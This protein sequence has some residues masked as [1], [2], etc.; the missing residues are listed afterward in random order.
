LPRRKKILVTP[1]DWGLGHAARCIP[2][3]RM[4]MKKNCDVVIA[5]CGRTFSLLRK[6]F[7]GMEMTWL[8]EYNPVYP[9]DDSMG[10]TMALQLPKFLKAIRQEHNEVRDIVKK[11]SID[12]VISDNRYGCYHEKVPSVFVTHQ[13]NILMPES[14]KW[15]EKL[16]NSY[17][18]RQIKK[19]TQCWVPAPAN[20]P[21]HSLTENPDGLPVKYIGYLSRMEKVPTQKKYGVCVICSGPEP[22]RTLME[23]MFNGDLKNLP[24]NTILVKGQTEKLNPYFNKE[25]QHLIANYLTTED[26]NEVLAESEIVFS[27]PGYST[28]MD[29]AKIG[30]KAVFIPTPGQTE[31]EYIAA[32]LM[33]QNIAL[34]VPQSGFNFEK[35]LKEAEKFDGFANFTNAESLLEAAIDSIL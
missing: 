21:F 11:L 32:E 5:T 35:A 25:Q 18:H 28:V 17:N 1:L 3:I 14:L 16:V 12:A 13:L 29:F 7:P 34:S 33:K 30:C 20:S 24:C 31:Q 23:E 15:A 2:I 26:L 8:A 6:E 10:F 19:F 4:L 9:K 22:Q 27:R